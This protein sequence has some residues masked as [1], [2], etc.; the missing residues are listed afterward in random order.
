MPEQ[1]FHGSAVFLAERRYRS[2]NTSSKQDVGCS[3]LSP[4]SGVSRYIGYTSRLRRTGDTRAA[5]KKRASLAAKVDRK[6]KLTGPVI[7]EF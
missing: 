4:P 3:M 1:S 7:L 5:P 6:C 2:Y